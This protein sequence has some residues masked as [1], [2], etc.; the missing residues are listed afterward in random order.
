[1]ATPPRE[2]FPRPAEDLRGRRKLR[3]GRQRRHGRHLVS[4]RGHGRRC[5]LGRCDTNRRHDHGRRRLR[6]GGAPT[7]G[8]TAMGG[9]R[10]G[11]RRRAGGGP[12]RRRQRRHRRV[13]TED[14]RRG[15]GG[16]SGWGERTAG[17]AAGAAAVVIAARI[18]RPR[19]GVAARGA[20]ALR[21]PRRPRSLGHRRGRHVLRLLHGARRQDVHRP[22]DL[23]IGRQA[24]RR[25]GLADDHH[26]GR[27]QSV[28]AGHL[29]LRRQVPPLL[30]GLDLRLEQVVHRAR[31]ADSWPRVVD[32]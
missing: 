28:G 13:F 15:S 2:V 30:R 16:T 9:G 11:G 22:D 3:F 14:R 23:A 26:L 31:H 27:R 32:R 7:A 24:L 6:D 19:F 5:G 21:Q 8:G 18:A 29:P 12:G 20:R 25:P 17:A 1:M 10:R 4:A